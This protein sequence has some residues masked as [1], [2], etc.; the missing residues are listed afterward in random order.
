MKKASHTKRTPAGKLHFVPSLGL[1]DLGKSGL[2]EALVGK[3]EGEFEVFA[4]RMHQGLLA[5]ALAG[6]LEVFSEVVEAEV[7]QVAG[8]NHDPI[9]GRKSGV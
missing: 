5:A 7:T 2:P 9:D 6:S 1:V 4:T 8:P 3:V